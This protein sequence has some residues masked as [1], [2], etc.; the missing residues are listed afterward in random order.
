[1][2]RDREA[3]P[4][5]VHG[6]IESDMTGQLNNNSFHSFEVKEELHLKRWWTILSVKHSK[7]NNDMKW[8]CEQQSEKIIQ[9]KMA[10]LSITWYMH[11]VVAAWSLSH[12]WLICDPGTIAHQAPLSMGF[13]RQEY[14]SRLPFPS[15][16]DLPNPRI[17]P[18]SSALGGKFFTTE[19]PGKS[20]LPSLPE[21]KIKWII[22]F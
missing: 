9:P 4:A 2:E 16:G 21:R 10:E 6:I 22:S 7:Q 19:P 3:W 12:V 1:M 8:A 17:E 15:P 13:S 18:M 14:L 5:A 11:V 20:N